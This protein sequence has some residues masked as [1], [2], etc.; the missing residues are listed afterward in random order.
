DRR[1]G[2][3][4]CYF[5]SGDTNVESRPNR[6]GTLGAQISGSGSIRTSVQRSDNGSRLLLWGGIPA[7]PLNHMAH[8]QFRGRL[9]IASLFWLEVNGTGWKFRKHP[10]CMNSLPRLHQGF[11]AVL[12][13]LIED[14]RIAAARRAG[15]QL[16]DLPASRL[17]IEIAGAKY[18]KV[19]RP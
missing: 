8:D 1:C 13:R 3:S 14:R 7:Q 10:A 9:R 16:F 17:A 5:A 19:Q 12:C 2:S 4:D 6:I 15:D 18:G 11:G